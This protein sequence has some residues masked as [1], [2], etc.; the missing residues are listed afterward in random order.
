MLFKATCIEGEW[1]ILGHTAQRVSEHP[2]GLYESEV[3]VGLT[4][5]GV[6]SSSNKYG[7]FIAYIYLP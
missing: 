2:W 1:Q 7:A 4:N 6:S 3:K 5:V